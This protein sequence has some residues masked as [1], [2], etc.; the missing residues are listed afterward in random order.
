MTFCTQP[1]RQ[2]MHSDG[3]MTHH[4]S[5]KRDHASFAPF[6]NFASVSVLS[7]ASLSFVVPV[8]LVLHTLCTLSVLLPIL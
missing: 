6:F 5:A 1:M 3:G 2:S 4:E 7:L 8:S